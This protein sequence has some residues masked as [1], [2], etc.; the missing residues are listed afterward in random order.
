MKVTATIVSLVVALAL[1]GVASAGIVDEGGAEGSSPEF[2]LSTGPIFS[3]AFNVGTWT[4][5]PA[6]V[7]VKWHTD[8]SFP[9]NDRAG[10]LVLTSG[11]SRTVFAASRAVGTP[12]AGWDL[13]SF[14]AFYAVDF[15]VSDDAAHTPVRSAV[16]GWLVAHN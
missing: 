13:C 11:E 9:V 1:A 6:P 4:Y 16:T 5:S 12:W 7:T 3:T 8:C 2:V 10:E 15:G 14:T